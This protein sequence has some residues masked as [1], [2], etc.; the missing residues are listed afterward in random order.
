MN[1]FKKL[2][3]GQKTTEEVKQEKEKDFDMVK[4]D[5]VRALRMHQFDLAAKSLEHAL[6]LNAEDLECRDYLSQAYISMGDCRK[7]MS[8]CRFSRKPRPTTWRCCCVWRMWR[9]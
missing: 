9:I 1:I 4:Y 6:Q 5:G 8:S 3:G 2:F 7:P